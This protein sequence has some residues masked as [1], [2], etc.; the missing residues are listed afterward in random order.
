MTFRQFVSL[1]TR[2]REIRNKKESNSSLNLVVRAYDSSV[3][4]EYFI[5]YEDTLGYLYGFTRLLLP[6]AE[7]ALDFEGL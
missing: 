1:D 4:R 6:L 3:G 5:S 2:S 7:H